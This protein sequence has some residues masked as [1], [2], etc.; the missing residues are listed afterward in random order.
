MKPGS[1][2]R[3]IQDLAGILLVLSIASWGAQQSQT[4]SLMRA[5]DLQ[6]GTVQPTKLS[7]EQR[8]DIFMVRRSFANAIEYYSR[9]IKSHHLSAQ[10]RAKVA[11][12]WNKIGICYQQELNYKDAR[13]AYRKAVRLDRTFAQAWNNLGTTYYLKKKAKKSIKYYRRAIKL[14]PLS[15]T[16]HV[17]LGT[18]YFTRKKYK[19]TFEEFRTAIK[20]DPEVLLQSSRQ[21]TEVEARH[22]TARF[23]FYMAKVYASLGDASKAVQYLERAMENGFDNR[24]QIL[25][26]PDM[27]KISKDPAFT[28]LMKNPPVGIK[29]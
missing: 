26:D 2:V 1:L 10:N 15:A 3:A 13:K 6:Q 23:Y 9:A 18:A 29:N 11:S 4:L 19:K 20:L 16:Y 8:A 21:G 14:N 5:Q 27:K 28:T 7:D 25:H 22:V 17:N 24:N 12:L